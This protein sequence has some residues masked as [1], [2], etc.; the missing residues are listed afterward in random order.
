MKRGEVVRLIRDAARTNR[1]YLSRHAVENDD[2]V[3]ADDIVYVL[4]HAKSFRMQPNGRW[5]VSGLD[6]TGDRLTVIVL[7]HEEKVIAWTTF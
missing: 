6:R 5:R 7:V 4:A 2:Y 3:M 1:V